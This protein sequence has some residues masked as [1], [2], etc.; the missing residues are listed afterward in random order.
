MKSPD[1][2]LERGEYLNI[3]AS[4]ERRLSGEPSNNALRWDVVQDELISG[5]LDKVDKHLKPLLSDPQYAN[6]ALYTQGVVRYFQG[7]HFSE[8]VPDT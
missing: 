8:R 7:R 5:N 3:I 4:K 1:E 2:R 6:D